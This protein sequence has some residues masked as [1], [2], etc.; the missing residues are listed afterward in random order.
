MPHMVK[1]KIS[2]KR[3]VNPKRKRKTVSNNFKLGNKGK[4]KKNGAKWR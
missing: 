4:K 2:K 3:S 1:E